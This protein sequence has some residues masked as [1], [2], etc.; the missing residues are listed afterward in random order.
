MPLG[1]LIDPAAERTRISKD[2]AKAE[3]EISGLEKKLG[4]ADF[5]ARAPK[6]VVDEQN[7]RLAEEQ[8]RRARLL[9]ALETLG[10]GAS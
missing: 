3:K 9:E 8:A 10:Q 5:L 4:N 7:A 2:L 1:G 6:E